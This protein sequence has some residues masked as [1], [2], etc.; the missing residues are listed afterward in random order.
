MKLY[1]IYNFSQKKWTTENSLHKSGKD[2][3]NFFQIKKVNPIFL[4]DMIK[5]IT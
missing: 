1:A 2:V 4:Q 5:K 3:S